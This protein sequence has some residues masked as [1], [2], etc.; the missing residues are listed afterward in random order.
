MCECV[1]DCM[2]LSSHSPSLAPHVGMLQSTA[3]KQTFGKIFV[4]RSPLHTWK[5]N[6]KI[7]KYLDEFMTA[8]HLL[9][10]CTLYGSGTHYRHI[11]VSNRFQRVPC[12]CVYFRASHSLSTLAVY[13]STYS[14]S[15]QLHGFF[16]VAVAWCHCPCPCHRGTFFSLSIAFK[17]SNRAQIMAT[18]SRI[19]RHP[20]LWIM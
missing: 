13:T 2:A 18:Y 19:A 5:G 9:P 12:A 10:E 16:C 6:D 3:I 15:G 17:G 11:T 1:S 20:H 7:N 14:A 8:L 4:K